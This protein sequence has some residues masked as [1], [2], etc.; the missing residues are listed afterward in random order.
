MT[1]PHPRFTDKVL[2]RYSVVKALYGTDYARKWFLARF[3]PKAYKVIIAGGGWRKA[4]P[5]YLDDLSEEEREWVDRTLAASKKPDP[6]T[7]PDG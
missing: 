6:E 4:P 7:S 5:S 1:R 2:K 3:G